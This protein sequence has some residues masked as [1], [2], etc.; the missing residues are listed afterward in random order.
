MRWGV[1]GRKA[2]VVAAVGPAAA[3]SLL[4]SCSGP[5]TANGTATLPGPAPA[6]T[7]TPSTSDPWAV[8]ATIDAT[9]VN[10][11]L[12]F[13]DHAQGNAVRS[14]RRANALTPEFTRIQSAIRADP[15]E[16]RLAIQVQE[17]SIKTGWSNL[18]SSPGD[19]STTVQLL[20]RVDQHCIVSAVVEDFSALTI[21]APIRYPAWFVG[22]V[23][24]AVS[25][26]NPTHWAISYDGYESTGGLPEAPCDLKA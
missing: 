14:V 25:A 15:H 12:A 10:R 6:S 19:R 11:V 7:A 20:L 17:N 16:I 8:P 9:Y 23:A 4:T 5:V 24:K 3:L 22:L 1:P 13:L 26:A 2:A 18:R 21:T